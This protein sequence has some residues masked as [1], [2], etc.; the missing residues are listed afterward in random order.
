M[1]ALKK[2][3]SV[4]C[5]CV[6]LLTAAPM[7]GFIGFEMS[8]HELVILSK[9]AKVVD[10]GSCG[11]NVSY[12]L[13]SDGVLTISGTGSVKEYS[14]LAAIPWHS[15][16]ALIKSVIIKNGVTSISGSLFAFCPML[17]TVTVEDSVKSIGSAAFLEC[18]SLTSVTFG[19]N[20]QL[21]HIGDSAFEG[22]FE[23]S[24]MNIPQGVTSLNDNVFYN[25]WSLKKVNISK[26]LTSIDNGALYCCVSLTDFVVDANNPSYSSE[27][28]VLYNKNKT[29]LIK[30]PAGKQQTSFVVP[31]TVKTI[32]AWAFSFSRFLNS[33]FIPNSVTKIGS[34]AFNN[35]TAL[36]AVTLPE[37]ITTIE[38]ST[39]FCCESLYYIFIPDNVT[40]IQG[41]AFSQCSAL[42]SVFL[43]QELSSIG[44]EAFWMSNAVNDVYYRGTKEKWK[45]VSIAADNDDLTDATIHYDW[46]QLAVGDLDKN[47]KIEAGDARL[48]LRASVKL[49]KLNAAQAKAADVDGTPGVSAADARLILRV[50]VKLDLFS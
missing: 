36:T 26:N 9:A 28:G 27:N 12:S 2:V 14:T 32:Q 50:A 45:K 48:A 46:Q 20:S 40:S 29:E 30:Y 33:V 38:S 19:A 47:T 31:S 43:P 49:E 16:S 8:G 4:F 11:T 35:C 10:S 21:T 34:S 39:F 41:S 15:D 22:C 25:C 24:E 17:T 37:N 3:L 1:K 13:N 18:A 5:V 7:S 44:T 42:T 6:M 23:L